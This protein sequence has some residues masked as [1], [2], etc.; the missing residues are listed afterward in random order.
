MIKPPE[1]DS[2]EG[3]VI[4]ET[5]NAS[6][7]GD[8]DALRR[9]LERDAGLSRAEYWYTPAIHFAVREGHLEAVRLL[10]EAGAT[11]EER[12]VSSGRAKARRQ[13]VEADKQREPK[14]APAVSMLMAPRVS[15]H[16]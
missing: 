5:L 4:W 10:V 9:L 14:D 1:L 8:V 3:D 13:A 2:A 7:E 6:H 11:I 16:G 12:F 15:D